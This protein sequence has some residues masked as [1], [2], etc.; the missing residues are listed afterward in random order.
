VD[1]SFYLFIYLFIYKVLGFELRASRLLGLPLEPLPQ[2][3]FLLGI[4][5]IRVSLF[6]WGWL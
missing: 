6:A 3:C 5:E 4:F 1:S 2:P